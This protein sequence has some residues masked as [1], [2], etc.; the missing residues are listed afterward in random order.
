MSFLI[1]DRASS[2]ATSGETGE[3]AS[4]PA[5]MSSSC[6]AMQTSVSFGSSPDVAKNLQ[7]LRLFNVDMIREL[8][9][10]DRYYI[11]DINYF[12]GVVTYF[13]IPVIHTSDL[14]SSFV[15]LSLSL[16]T[17]NYSN[18]ILIKS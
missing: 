15:V 9:N 3:G 6:F 5:G 10:K 8:G 1:H 18:R 4:Q 13:V 17:Q 12:P 2:K 11:I 16:S 7:G 14:S